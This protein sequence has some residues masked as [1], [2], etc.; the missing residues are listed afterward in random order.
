M[1]KSALSHGLHRPPVFPPP[2]D[3]LNPFGS[4]DFLRLGFAVSLTDIK[5]LK[6]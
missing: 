4:I 5:R 1:G 3:E 2:T 6:S